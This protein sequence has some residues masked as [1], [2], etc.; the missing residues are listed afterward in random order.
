MQPWSHRIASSATMS[1]SA[2]STVIGVRAHL[3]RLDAAGCST[4]LDV[5][6]S[7]RPPDGAE[8]LHADVGGSIGMR[9][10]RS[11][12]AFGCATRCLVPGGGERTPPL[13][14]RSRPVEAGGSPSLETQAKGGSSP[15]NAGTGRHRQTARVRLARWEGVNADLNQ[16]VKLRNQ[17]AGSN[18]VDVGRSAVHD[19]H[20]CG[21]STPKP[22]P[23]VGGEATPKV[24]GVGVA[25]LPGQSW[26]PPP[27]TGAW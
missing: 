23:N 8:R 3:V 18:L 5:Q 22:V 27:S 14:C 24:C 4:Q 10:C 9:R 6:D 7:D 20:L 26:T 25:R 15:D 19:H 2:G 1:R 11:V 12:G 21:W 16:W 17:H 13:A